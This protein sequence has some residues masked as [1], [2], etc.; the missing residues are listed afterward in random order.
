[1]T[2]PV[3]R[4]SWRVLKRGPLLL[5]VAA[6]AILV[7]ATTA[8]LNDGYAISVLRGA[9]ILL[10]CGLA[11][12]LD[13]PAADLLAASPT[14]VA[15]R[16]AARLLLAAGL[17]AFAW[18]LLLVWVDAVAD[19]VP[20]LALSV[21]AAALGA[22]AV[23]VAAALRRWREVCEPGALTAPAV[24]G[25]VLAANLLPQRWSLLAADPSAAGWTAS[26]LRWAALLGA[27]VVVV[28]AAAQDPGRRSTRPSSTPG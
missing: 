18:I 19:A 26:H 25:G 14:T 1:M 28:A 17:T 2:G 10:A 9:A 24:F 8:A 3:L 12:V 13:D 23:A 16:W 7:G 6:A 21:E 5:S 11:L 27:A 4:V 15:R 20:W 22:F